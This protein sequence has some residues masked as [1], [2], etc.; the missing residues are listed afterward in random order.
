MPSDMYFEVRE[1]DVVQLKSESVDSVRSGWVEV[2]P[3]SI[4]VQY[5]EQ[6]GNLT[7][8]AMARGNEQ[9][10]LATLV[11]AGHVAREHGGLD[12]DEADRH[13]ESDAQGKG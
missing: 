3:H 5:H 8:K 11:V 9:V 12:E 13:A 1:N 2:D 6:A 10:P 4:F 7:V